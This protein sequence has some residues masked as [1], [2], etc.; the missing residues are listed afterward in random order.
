MKSG[1]RAHHCP[2]C[3][4]WPSPRKRCDGTRAGRQLGSKAGARTCA[5][6][7][8]LHRRSA[9]PPARDSA[10]LRHRGLAARRHRTRRA[11]DR[12]PARLA[13]RPAGFLPGQRMDR[14]RPSQPAH[15]RGVGCGSRLSWTRRCPPGGRGGV[16]GP[17]GRGYP[18]DPCPCRRRDPVP[19][20]GR[21]DELL[22]GRL[23]R[24]D[25]AIR[26]RCG[27]LVELPR[28]L[29]DLVGRRHDRS[30]CLCSFR[31]A[32]EPAGTCCPK[33]EASG[34][35]PTPARIC[36]SRCPVRPGQQGGA[37]PHRER[38]RRALNGR[39]PG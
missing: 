31:R 7:R 1:A 38:D 39:H 17:T 35:P 18:R 27:R 26:S 16:P 23:R 4:Q 22:G 29:D 28:Q 30:A 15:H 24:R 2:R 11:A 3:D 19:F 5:G 25:H 36:I 14:V 34:I 33:A 32:L 10:R 8:V 6:G 21:A 13:W 37:G 12:R 20:R 9:R